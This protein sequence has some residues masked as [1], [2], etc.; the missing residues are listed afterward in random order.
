MSSPRTELE[1]LQAH[2][3][4]LADLAAATRSR[5]LQLLITIMSDR[6]AL[7][8]LESG[9]SRLLDRQEAVERDQVCT[10]SHTG[11]WA[12][13][14]TPSCHGGIIEDDVWDCENPR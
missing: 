1:K 3:Q 12:P 7:A 4:Q 10:H 6:A 8:G 13:K 5:L 11:E 2:F 14:R 9:V